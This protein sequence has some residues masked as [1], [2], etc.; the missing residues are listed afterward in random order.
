MGAL[1]GEVVLITGG[2][3]GLGR[4]IVERF[5]EEGARIAVLDRTPARLTD[6]TRVHADKLIA[7]AGDVRSIGDNANAVERC[8]A[9]FG[10]LEWSNALIID[11]AEVDKNFANA[12]RN[13]PQIDVLPVCST[14]RE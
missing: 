11:G 14:G 7:I 6:L 1:A 2:A 10:K 12:A 3:S 4:A 5:L 9:K 13:I 8:V